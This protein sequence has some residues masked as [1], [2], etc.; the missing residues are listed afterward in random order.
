MY[1]WSRAVF[2]GVLLWAIPF[3][4]MFVLYPLRL[5]AMPL[6]A[7]LRTIILCVGVVFFTVLYFRDAENRFLGEGIKLGVL[8]ALLSI[9]FDQ[10]PYVFG[11]MKMSFFEYMRDTGL[12]YMVY[13][14]VTGGTGF[15]LSSVMPDGE[16]SPDESAKSPPKVEPRETGRT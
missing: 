11:G 16:K 7:S 6:F 5:T 4:M 8:W 3:M 9:L 2:Y 14:I 12:N 15:L 10:V 13:P 1:S